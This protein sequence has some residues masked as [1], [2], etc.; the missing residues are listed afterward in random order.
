ML[1]VFL[2]LFSCSV[3]VNA[4]PSETPDIWI[5]PAAYVQQVKNVETESVFVLQRHFGRSGRIEKRGPAPW[6]WKVKELTIVFRFEKRPQVG[7]VLTEFLTLKRAWES[8]G[9]T[10]RGLQ[11]DYDSP[12]AKLGFY[13]KDLTQILDEIRKKTPDQNLSI[14][15]LTDWL[16]LEKPEFGSGVTVYF[17]F[18]REN[19]MHSENEMYIE[20]LVRAKFPFKIGLLPGQTLTNR[21]NESLT[22]ASQFRGFATFFGGKRL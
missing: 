16:T 8:K 11:L 9:V 21:Q 17:Q 5:W 3:L 13:Q 2:L 19:R 14:T 18:Y 7:E 20:R 10:V 22:Q 12:T 6:P 1:I 4:A 15:G